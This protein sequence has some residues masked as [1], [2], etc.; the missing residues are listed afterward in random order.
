M[1]AGARTVAGW[2]THGCRLGTPTVAGC[3]HRLGTPTVAGCTH[4]VASLTETVA[5]WRH[6]VAGWDTHGC[7]LGRTG[8]AGW[9]LQ[10]G[11]RRDLGIWP[12][13]H[14]PPPL[15]TGP[16]AA[17]PECTAQP[18]AWRASPGRPW[19]KGGPRRSR[20]RP[21]GA[22]CALS[23]PFLHPPFLC[24]FSALSLPFLCA[25]CAL[26]APF[27]CASSTH[28]APFLRRFLRPVSAL[29]VA[30]PVRCPVHKR[31]HCQSFSGASTRCS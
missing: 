21:H 7:W 6:T 28:S 19:G 24:A 27:L 5:G 26:P 12:P 17:R 25:F 8:V 18:G 11:R 29:P 15:P 22:S 30:L 16:W 13:P 10:G 14:A 4:T 23:L 31:A 1:Q 9:R 3:T 20:P 2:G